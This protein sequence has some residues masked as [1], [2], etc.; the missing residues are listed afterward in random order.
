MQ[1]S[2]EAL[3]DVSISDVSI[4]GASIGY[5]FFAASASLTFVTIQRPVR[6]SPF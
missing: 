6:V 1:G 3:P 2:P 5:D 4:S